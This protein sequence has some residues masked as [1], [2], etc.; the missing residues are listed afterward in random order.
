MKG[1]I[2]VHMAR[3]CLYL[4]ILLTVGCLDFGAFKVSSDGSGGTAGDAPVGG[5]VPG[6]GGT[7]GSAGAEVG[8]GGGTG[9]TGGSGPGPIG[10]CISVVSRP[11]ALVDDFDGGEH[12]G[13]SYGSTTFEGNRVEL[14]SGSGNAYIALYGLP[15]VLDNCYVEIELIDAQAGRVFVLWRG[16]NPNEQTFGLNLHDGVPTGALSGEVDLEDTS[17]FPAGRVRI[18]EQGG[19]YFIHTSPPDSDEWSV[20]YTTTDAPGWLANQ[21]TFILGANSAPPGT[22]T[23]AD[24]FGAP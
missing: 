23:I 17:T 2:G 16:S 21:G 7:G 19:S 9:G 10:P 8:G 20:R 1:K 22:I 11:K 5:G 4:S 15:A 12:L 14:A 6:G 18:G 3:S 24:N 13:W